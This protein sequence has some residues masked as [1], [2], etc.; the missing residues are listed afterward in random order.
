MEFRCFLA[1]FLI[2]FG[3]KAVASNNVIDYGAI[4]NDGIDD[5]A[6]FHRAIENSDSIVYVPA[7]EFNL[8]A[9]L[10]FKGDT[11][12]IKGDGIGVSKLVWASGSN[13]IYVEPPSGKH[14]AA[15]IQGLTLFTKS[16]NSGS[17]YQYNGKN[18]IVNDHIQPRTR[19]KVIVRDVELSGYTGATNSGWNTGLIIDTALG[20]HIDGYYFSGQVKNSTNTPLSSRGIWMRGSG[21]SVQVTIEEAEIY[22]TNIAIDVANHEGLYI[23]ESNLVFVNYGLKFANSAVEPQ[24][25]LS[26]SHLNCKIGCVWL[27][28]V[29]QVSIKDNLMYGHHTSSQS[30]FGVQLFGGSDHY[31]ISNN[32]FINT[33]GSFGFNGVV[34]HSD[35]GIISGNIF[36]LKNKGAGV[37]FKSSA[38]YGKAFNNTCNSC[39]TKGLNQG[40]GTNS[41]NWLW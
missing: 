12:S 11:L 28:K 20:V 4:P 7:G 40:G 10:N 8:S 33:S 41:I 14:K 38:S 18:S 23:S 36:S 19:P 15:V 5:T 9:R 26:N 31:N 30:V 24:L 21:H 17:A 32:T 27:D 1:I 25:N 22:Y 29:A 37:W 6:A 13:G 3:V 16:S 35:K 39:A 34:V 2:F